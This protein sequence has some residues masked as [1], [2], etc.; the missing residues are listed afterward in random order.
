[1]WPFYRTVDTI[2]HQP[3]PVNYTD[4]RGEFCG[5]T[6]LMELTREHLERIR[7]SLPVERGKPGQLNASFRVV[8]VELGK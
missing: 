3:G 5:V 1:M 2:L 7:E 8:S 6:G 4:I